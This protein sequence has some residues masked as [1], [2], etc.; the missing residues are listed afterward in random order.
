MVSCFLL[1]VKAIKV[2]TVEKLFIELQGSLQVEGID[3]YIIIQYI[4]IIM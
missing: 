4:K 2:E 1:G 3:F